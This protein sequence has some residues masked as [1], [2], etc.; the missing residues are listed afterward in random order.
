M[1]KQ[2]D[3]AREPR[4]SKCGKAC[5]VVYDFSSLAKGDAYSVSDVIN[6]ADATIQF[7][8][9][10]LADGTWTTNGNAK[11]VMSTFAAGS[12]TKELNLNNIMMRVIAN[13]SAV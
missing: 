10:Q 6:V 7:T 8:Q 13:T 9:F 11:V 1:D 2:E 12:P 5:N 3:S 4:T